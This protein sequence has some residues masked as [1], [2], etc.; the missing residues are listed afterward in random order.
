LGTSGFTGTQSNLEVVAFNSAGVKLD[1]EI[2][3]SGVEVSNLVC[4]MMTLVIELGT[5]GFTSRK[6]SL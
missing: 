5:S 3:N 1:I 6:S 4:E 2:V